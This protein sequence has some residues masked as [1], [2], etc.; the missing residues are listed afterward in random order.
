MESLRLVYFTR[1]G[2]ARLPAV[3]LSL[4]GWAKREFGTYILVVAKTQLSS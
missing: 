1:L 4:I 3:A 2:S